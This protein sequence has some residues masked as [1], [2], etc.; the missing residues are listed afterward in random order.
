MILSAGWL[1]F[2]EVVLFLCSFQWILILSHF[3][4]PKTHGPLTLGQWI[5]VLWAVYTGLGC[6]FGR[7]LL[8]WSA[9]RSITAAQR[10][11]PTFRWS[12]ANLLWIVCASQISWSGLALHMLGG[13]AWLVDALFVIG[14]ILLLIWRPGVCLAAAQS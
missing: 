11:T 2:V 1:R 3:R 10:L 5:V 4:Y 8:D 12:A 14:M 9:R 6:V 7:Q 13:P